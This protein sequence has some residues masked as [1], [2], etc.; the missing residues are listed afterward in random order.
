MSLAGR[1]EEDG[2]H[3]KR[4]LSLDAKTNLTLE[5]AT[6]RGFTKSSFVEGAVKAYNADIKL[7]MVGWEIEN[8]RISMLVQNDSDEGLLIT[9]LSCD[10][11]MIKHID[12]FP[13][14]LL[15]HRQ[16]EGSCV[17][18]FR[19]PKRLQTEGH[20]VVL[21]SYLAEF[22]LILDKTLLGR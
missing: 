17:I 16:S 8:G 22:S 1:P 6:K 10:G 7:H 13:N 21:F 14:P 4:K 20:S 15:P 3:V 12:V 5:K 9:Q 11:Q 2:G 18:S 19:L